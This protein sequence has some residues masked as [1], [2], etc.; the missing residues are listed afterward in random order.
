M[1]LV[2]FAHP[3]FLGQQSMPRFANMLASGMLARGHRVETWT[4][5]P[6]F[7]RLP[8]P[9]SLKKWLGYIDQYI[10]FPWEV[11]RRIARGPKDVLFVFTD[12][13]LG[14]WVPMVSHLPHVI[15]C[16]D[17]LAQKSARGLIPENPTRIT[18][19]FYQAFIR[20]GYRKG[21]NFISV[22]E[23]TKQDLANF[24]QTVPV[25]SDVV[26]NGFNQE[27]SVNDRNLVR[28]S[29]SDTFSIDLRVGYLLHV[30]GNAWYK[31]RTGVIEIYNAWR[32]GYGVKIPLLL[33]GESPS[34]ELLS[35]HA[36]SPF[37]ADI[38]FLSN[39]EDKDVRLAYSGADAFLFPSLA[40]GFG[41]P[42]AEAMASGCPVITTNEPPMTEV[43]GDAASLIPK[44]PE[45]HSDI[46]DW[47]T[48]A[49]RVVNSIM[50]MPAPE[51]EG[52]VARGMM[53]SKRFNTNFALDKIEAI[54]QNI[55]SNEIA[56]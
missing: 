5:K 36:Q 30:G 29:L 49:A 7:F 20:R 24:L 2:F 35:L 55:L 11:R 3:T 27:F 4:P 37:G 56:A 48:R 46:T 44:R 17:F 38:Y 40:E 32:S 52:I 51:R 6:R 18:G 54:Y 53:N 45:K 22:S 16:H 23:K 25:I 9:E 8:V 43:A 31:N 47:A 28:A 26:Y 14:P 21:K 41:W 34:P 19:R 15:H 1:Q 12:N 13:A 10:I 42:I 39:V 50:V 33:V